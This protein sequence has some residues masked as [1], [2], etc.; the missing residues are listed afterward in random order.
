MTKKHSN[1]KVTRKSLIAALCVLSVACSGL[2]AACAPNKEEDKPS[3]N[4]KEDT[5]LL[6]NGNFE[7]FNVPEDAVHLIKNVNG[8]TIDGGSSVKSGIISTGPKAWEDISDFDLGQ[9]LDY[10][11]DIGSSSEDYVDYNS[12]RSRDILYKEPYAATRTK[13]QLKDD[14]IIKN[15]GGLQKFLGIEGEDGNYKFMGETVYKNA[16]DGDFYFD[17]DFTR[18]VRQAVI[19]NPET[20][21]GAYSEKDG[22]YYLGTTEVY[23]DDDGNLYSDS[24]KEYNTGNV[25][26]VHNYT[27][28]GKYNGIRQYY[29]SNTLTLE[30]NT[31]AEIS[32][33]VKTSDL[34]FD[35]GYSALYDQ[36]KGASIEVVQTVNGT[37]IDTF[38]IKNINT[39]K[40]IAGAETD[41]YTVEESNGWLNYKIYINA[42][43]FASS[44]IQLRLGL[45]Q[46]NEEQCTG[47]AFFDDV[48]VKKFRS[49]DDENCT[50]SENKKEIND[51][52]TY[53]SLTSEADD[54][55]FN[56]DKELRKSNGTDF[57]HAYHFNYSVDLASVAS[58]ADNS[59]YSPV[60]L[61]KDN[62]SVKLTTEKDGL[63]LYASSAKNDARLIGI[64]SG[65][66]D[67]AYDLVKNFNGRPTENDLLGTFKAGSQFTESMFAG[68][69]Y[70][71]DYSGLLNEALNGDGQLPDYDGNVLMMLSAWGAAY[72]STV[73]STNFK[74]EANGYTIVSFWL[75]TSDANS[76][77]KVYDVNDDENSQTLTINTT[78]VVTNFEK[79]KNIYNGW[80]PCF[81][82]VQND[83]EEAQEFNIDLGYGGSDI[84]NAKYAGG[85]TALANM[86]TLSVDEE[87][88][89]L[90][91]SGTYTAL[92]SFSE[93][94]KSSDNKVMDEPLA[95]SDIR[96]G[97]AHPS[98]YSGL[99]GAH[100][101]ISGGDSNQAYDAG[102]TNKL[103]GLISKEHFDKY[104]NGNDIL[105]SFNQSAQNWN[106]VFGENCYQPLIIINNLRTY[107][108]KAE[109]NETNFKDYY[110]EDENGTIVAHNGKKF[111]K[112]AQ[113][114][115]FDEETTYY[116][117]K[118]VCN[119]GFVSNGKTVSSNSY[120]TV[121]IKVMVSGDAAAYIYLVDN[122]D[123]TKLLN[124]T[125]PGYTFFYDK[126]G[127]VLDEKFDED[128]KE[129]EH[130][131]HIIYTLRD[132]GLYESKDS[133]EDKVYYANLH[134]LRRSFKNYK[135]EHETFYNKDG[136]AV[137]FDNLVDGEDYYVSSAADRLA[138]HYLT[139][140]EGTRIYE[141]KSEDD[142]YYYIAEQKTTDVKVKNFAE[143]YA[144][145]NYEALNEELF[146][147][148]TDTD[149]KWVTVNF[150]IHTGSDSKNYR[151]EMWSGDRN[152][153]GVNNGKISNGAVAFDYSSFSVTSSNYAS[154]LGE[155]EKEI[156]NKYRALLAEYN[157]LD[158][159]TSESENIAFYE[160]TLS[161]LVKD[162]TIPADKVNAIA[163]TY[164]A[165]YYTYTLY[166]SE[167]YVPFN[168]TTAKDGETGYEYKSEDFKE[169]LAYFNY[170]NSAQN[171]HNVFVDYSAV[172]QDIKINSGNADEDEDK[173]EDETETVDIWLYVSSI[174]LAAVLLLTLAAILIRNLI[175]KRIIKKGNSKRNKNV[176]RQRDRYIKKL[177][178]VKNE[179][180][181]DAQAETN[182]DEPVETLPAEEEPEATEENE[183]IS[184]EAAEPS[185]DDED[186]PE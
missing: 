89:R 164:D 5:Q 160:K 38:A 9:K 178:L 131:D 163:G 97:I 144:R 48:E 55:V 44:T 16:D 112:V 180:A 66:R 1:G 99:N 135:Y 39:E 134:N 4:Q 6:T 119:Y 101:T 173:D 78:G 113:N 64:S 152:E 77:V 110:V 7:F 122:T 166:D 28:D 54:K 30:A 153:T 56:A 176:Y 52:K 83:T 35:K 109:A 74:V 151:L 167:S 51:N 81:I 179:E 100:S 137:S 11:E 126:E 50:Y 172:D 93:S 69:N 65:D 162:G 22:K 58:T 62:V 106:D 115:T 42:C 103:A 156:I 13:D 46:T 41:G 123:T 104:S 47:Y 79:E 161:E 72:T 17:Q 26:M 12:M 86:Q 147:K 24:A 98:N 171:S 76:T 175:K 154:V 37:S 149:G 132:D 120:E 82:F 125:T 186:K 43:D 14:T 92:F 49:L 8:W 136:E 31:A 150:F 182:E 138:N 20:H 96:D 53:C 185:N 143:E 88:Y 95:T 168:A 148:V 165:K 70:H 61:T 157:K 25:L 94:E 60:N 18:P 159:I 155:Y 73:S 23:K 121:S 129:S 45:G 36:D 116:S 181:D 85:W 3:N 117:L 21:L 27:T 40:I 68:A 71:K 107:A 114:A 63:K 184:E 2:A 146:V 91:T 108:N 87:V 142:A 34:K 57:R 59:G 174:I 15:F 133:T 33:W 80:V 128:W 67:E 118:D 10:N 158:V 183:E 127:N 29:S 124:Y 84:K 19:D 130:R 90:A 145:Y 102:N 177:H 32:V 170:E 139:N 75:K 140:D 169:V 141:Y 111:S 105:K